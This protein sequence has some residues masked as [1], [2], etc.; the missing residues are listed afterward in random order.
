[1]SEC[2]EVIC[3]DTSAISRPEWLALRR[4]GLGSS[5]AAAAMSMS[6]W[7][8]AYS[9]WAEKRGLTP[10]L[11][12][13]ERF[14]W[15]RLHEPII[16]DQCVARGWVKEPMQRNLMVRHKNMPWMLANPDGLTADA[17]VEAKQADGFTRPKWEEGV[18]DH[19]VIQALWL[20]AVTGRP[21]T[22]FPVLFGGNELCRYVVEWDTD[23]ILSMTTAGEVM[24]E[25]IVA[26]RPPDADGSEASMLALRQ[27]YT[28]SIE[29]S[30]IELPLTL[31]ARLEDRR[32]WTERKKG[33]EA[34]IDEVNAQVMQAMGNNVLALMAGYP[35]ATWKPRKDGVRVFKW[36]E[37]EK[38]KR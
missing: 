1:M 5:D 12:D 32:L 22:I 19:Y 8:S 29:G 21:R 34:E 16:L 33:A 23:T 18:P 24:W 30:S 31:E 6:P 10:E 14:L 37:P 7:T 27:V 2:F 20:M 26:N 3:E 15:G 36:S 35:A 9:L 11:E 25:R 4:E 38:E 17:V 28:E 13:N